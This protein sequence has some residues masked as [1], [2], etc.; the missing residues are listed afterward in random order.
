MTRSNPWQLS[1]HFISRCA[2]LAIPLIAEAPARA[3][4]KW[5]EVEPA[6]TAQPAP[7]KVYLATGEALRQPELLPER[8]ARRVLSFEVRSAAG[9]KNLVSS[10]RED[11]QPIAALPSLAPGSHLIRFDTSPIDIELDAT[12]F[13][14]YLLDER[15]IDV[16]VERQ[17]RSE[18]D[19]PGR[20]RYSRHLKALV[21]VGDKLDPLVTQ[22]VGQEHEIVPLIMPHSLRAGQ[23]LQVKVLFHGQPLSGRAVSMAQKW[24]GRV[25]EVFQRT[26]DAGIAKFVIEPRGQ[27]LVRL[28]HMQRTEG[29]DAAAGIDWRS[30]WASLS[31][32]YPEGSP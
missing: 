6:V 24:R 3:H 31:F 21:Q 12:K 8:R 13:G 19:K 18:E 2:L 22:P 32:S 23:E 1:C 27:W 16:L 4:D 5:L 10:F 29:S 14:A 9:V 7:T 15:L 30:H 17:R 11:Q 25:S 20:E 26:N 28:I